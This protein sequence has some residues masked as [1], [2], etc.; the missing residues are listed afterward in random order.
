MIRPNKKMADVVYRILKT[1]KSKQQK[2]EPI[3]SDQ[4]KKEWF[5]DSSTAQ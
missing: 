1:P 3:A 5:R 2:N 4:K